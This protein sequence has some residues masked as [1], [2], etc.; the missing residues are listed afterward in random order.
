M[1][2]GLS[3][4]VPPDYLCRPSD[5]HETAASLGMAKHC[6]N[7]TSAAEAAQSTPSTHPETAVIESCVCLQYRW[8]VD[9]GW[10]AHTRG[11]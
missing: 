2:V 1:F 4:V 11:Y 5:A 10:E 9:M 3:T 6:L 8:C 7:S